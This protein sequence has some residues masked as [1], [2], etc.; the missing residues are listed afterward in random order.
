MAKSRGKKLPGWTMQTATGCGKLYVTVNEKDGQPFEL[1]ATM[2]KAGGCSSCLMQAIGRI[3][4]VALQ[5]GTEPKLLIKQMGGLSCHSPLIV[6]D[7]KT[8]S[9]ADAISKVLK[10]YQ[11]S[12]EVKG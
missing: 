5:N 3:A 12:K 4:S 2:G 11:E 8:L 1:F 10:E 7:S 6:G 9:C